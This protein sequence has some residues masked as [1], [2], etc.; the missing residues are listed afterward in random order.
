MTCWNYSRPEEDGTY[1]DCTKFGMIS[2]HSRSGPQLFSH[3]CKFRRATVGMDG[4]RPDTF[5]QYLTEQEFG[6]NFQ[7]RFDRLKIIPLTPGNL[8]IIPYMSGDQSII[9]PIM[10]N[11]EMYSNLAPMLMQACNSTKYIKRDRYGGRTFRLRLKPTLS[12]G[13]LST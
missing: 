6:A 1:S 11:P 2:N 5:M 12:G 9:S 8:K 3:D 7:R 4:R 10:S 13:C